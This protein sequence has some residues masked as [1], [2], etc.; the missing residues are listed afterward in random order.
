MNWLAALPAGARVLD[1][2]AGAGRH[3]R[4]AAALGLQVVAVDRDVAALA[5]G[6]GLQVRQADLEQ[7]PWPFA[8]GEAYD[9]VVVSRY[10]F[11]PRF[12]LLAA[13]LAPGGRLIYETFA[14]GNERY[15]RPSNPAFLL[16][17]GELLE[18]SRRAGLVVLS[19][20]HGFTP[21]PAPAV[22]QRVCAV[23]PPLDEPAPALG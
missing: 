17:A 12:A 3:A 14:R 15:G 5:A 21:T 23:R 9:A 18:R 2:A 19:Y 10:L 6:P 20:E 13:L 22:M 4:A 11:R 16:E 1:L 7:G 8:D